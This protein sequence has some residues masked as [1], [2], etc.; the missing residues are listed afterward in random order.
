MEKIRLGVIGTGII[1]EKKHLPALEQLSELYEISA[2]CVYEPDQVQ[3]WT[4]RLPSAR[5]FS[6]YQELV[7]APEIDAVLVATPI[8]LNHVV[9]QA[10][11]RAGKDVFEEKP[12][13]T[14]YVEAK[15]ILD[16]EKECGK[17]VRM[18]EQMLYSGWMKVIQEY[19]TQKKLGEPVMFEMVS[20]AFRDPAT[21]RSGFT[22][23]QWRLKPQFP[24]G[25]IFDGGAHDIAIFTALFG[26]PER[27]FSVGAKFR[28]IMGEYDHILNCFSYPH[29]LSGVY[30]HSLF[31]GGSNNFFNIR[32]TNGALYL[33]NGVLTAEPKGGSKE[34]VPIPDLS[35][36]YEMWKQ[37]FKDYTHLAPGAFPSHVAADSIRIFD[38]IAQSIK[39]HEAAAV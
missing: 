27:V 24:L 35:S 15:K 39:N 11:L 28:E 38:A 34:N 8:H 18:L 33:Q 22:G 17:K 16:L 23:T 5:I 37:L 20:H 1:W 13:A 31:L 19:V 12:I 30:S 2:L 21:D 29:S 25:A 14:S 7:E 32:F 4:E 26:V 36:H 6:E 3:K 9:T 10:A